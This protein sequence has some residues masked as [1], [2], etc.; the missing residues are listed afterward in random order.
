MTRASIW[1][2][3]I[4]VGQYFL[5]SYGGPLLTLAHASLMRCIQH[6]FN[7]SELATLPFQRPDVSWSG[8][9]SRCCV[10]FL[11]LFGRDIFQGIF[12]WQ[13]LLNSIFVLLGQVWCLDR[14]LL[15]YQFLEKRN[16]K[17]NLSIIS[18]RNN[19]RHCNRLFSLQEDVST[20]AT[21][22]SEIPQLVWAKEN[23]ARVLNSQDFTP[24]LFYLPLSQFHCLYKSIKRRGL[25]TN[26]HC[27]PNNGTH[28]ERITKRI[29][30]S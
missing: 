20:E 8:P 12:P 27:H 3:T 7:C 11:A 28:R 2:W 25:S 30:K 18:Y 15:V 4:S 23:D 6:T 22:S 21:K 19:L 9:I 13:Q 29:W 24:V 17:K 10:L 16:E 14:P 5:L 1:Q 26:L